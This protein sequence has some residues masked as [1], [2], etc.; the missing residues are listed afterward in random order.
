MGYTSRMLPAEEYYKLEVLGIPRD[1]LPNPATSL[2]GVIEK[3][4][5]IIGRWMAL[6][7]IMFEGLE[8]KEAFQKKPGVARRLLNL[9]LGELRARGIMAALTIVQDETVGELARHAGFTRIPG[10]LYQKDLRDK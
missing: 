3:D 5:E 4:G 8:I 1:R 2:V 7:V 10:V 9:M 6:N